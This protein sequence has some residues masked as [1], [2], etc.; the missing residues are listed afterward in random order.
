M[1]TDKLLA[2]AKECGAIPNGGGLIWEFT[3]TELT[4]FAAKVRDAERDKWIAACGGPHKERDGVRYG[5]GMREKFEAARQRPD[6]WIESVR[7]N[8]LTDTGEG[9][10][11]IDAAE[12]EALRADKARLDWMGKFE[13]I[14]R[15][16]SE[17]EVSSA[18]GDD[19]T[20][21]GYSKD[22]RTAIDNAMSAGSDK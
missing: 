19:P 11:T 1:N 10:V 12:L 22:L 18:D 3:P 16:Y 4:A 5:P 7:L 20:K 13:Y 21:F 15:T 14:E 8:A 9:T 6:Y 2:L 17:F